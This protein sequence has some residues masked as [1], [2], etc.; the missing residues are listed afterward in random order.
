MLYLKG[1]VHTAFLLFFA[2]H[3][4]ITFIMDAQVILPSTPQILSEMRLWYI[5]TYKDTLMTEPY[6]LFLISFVYC[7]VFFQVPFF[8]YAVKTLLSKQN[9]TRF[10][11]LSLIYGSH[12]VTTLVPILSSILFQENDEYN[13]NSLEKCILFCFYFPYLIFPLW[14]VIIALNSEDMFGSDDESRQN[15]K[16]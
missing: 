6:D 10:R 11:L 9:S 8:F 13:K 16:D 1:W 4:P 7:E 14:L 15:K 3:I 5:T 2:S 12:T